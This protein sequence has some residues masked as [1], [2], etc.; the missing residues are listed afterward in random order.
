VLRIDVADDERGLLQPRDDAQRRE[1]GN[2]PEVSVARVPVGVA[3]TRNGLHLH[4]DRKQIQAG[5]KPLFAEHV[6]EEIVACDA[7]AHETPL[8]IGEHAQD[9]V[10]VPVPDHGLQTLDVKVCRQDTPLPPGRR[11]A[12]RPVRAECSDRWRLRYIARFHPRFAKERR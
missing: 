8:Q 4:I 10:D 2:Q 3:V 1:V 11:G 6:I 5:V 9:G 7:L 12:A